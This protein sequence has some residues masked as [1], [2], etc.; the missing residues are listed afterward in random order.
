MALRERRKLC[1]PK[2][3]AHQRFSQK[4][5]QSRRD[6]WTGEESSLNS[7]LG[8]GVFVFCYLL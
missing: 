6:L 1:R 5:M 8:F 3:G 7:R 4:G 2:A